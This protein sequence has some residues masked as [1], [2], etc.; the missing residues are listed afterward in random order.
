M[1]HRA[2]ARTELP[3]PPPGDAAVEIE[4]SGKLGLSARIASRTSASVLR[5]ETG[6]AAAHFE[7]AH[8]EAVANSLRYRISLRRVAAAAASVGASVIVLKGIAHDVLGVTA[9]G[10]RP[11]GDLDV[12]VRLSEIPRLV[13][14]LVSDGWTP[15]PFAGCDHQEAPLL[16]PSLG[17]LEVHRFIPGVRMPGALRAFDA[18]GLT[19]AGLTES[20][21]GQPDSVR[22]PERAVLVAHS[23]VHG[24][25]Q[26]AYSP[27]DY[28]LFRFIADLHDFGADRVSM[29][30]AGRYLRDVDTGDLGAVADLSSALASG[31]AMDAVDGASRALL[32]HLLACYLEP[33]YADALRRENRFLWHPSALPRPLAALSWAYHVS[34]LSRAQVDAI[35]GRPKCPGGYAVRR[36]FRPFDLG[37]RLCRSLA[38]KLVSRR[39]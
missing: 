11:Y 4:V 17:V 1:L 31:T 36:L 19:R 5:A 27:R 35:Y 28:P 34:V 14:A 38:E 18:Q 29:N 21:R 30:A 24:L 6:V 23:L 16:H 26:H 10:A 25:C 12:L 8:L 39:A 32:H 7:H 3:A 15:K 20:V 13:A 33:A 22:V 9:S 37:L 2:F